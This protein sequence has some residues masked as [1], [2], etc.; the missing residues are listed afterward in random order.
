MGQGVLP[1]APIWHGWFTYQVGQRE[2]R[3]LET[4][5]H[6]DAGRAWEGGDVVRV[7]L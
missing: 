2:A 7:G 3:I 5:T 6:H 1:E 4:H